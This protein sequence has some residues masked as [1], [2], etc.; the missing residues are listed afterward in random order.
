MVNMWL[1]NT[2]SI[3]NYRDIKNLIPKTLPPR[4]PP[5]ADPAAVRAN[6]VASM[7]TK[8]QEAQSAKGKGKASSA[9]HAGQSARGKQK[10]AAPPP[11][12]SMPPDPMP[13]SA[14]LT[15]DASTSQ[16]PHGFSF[17]LPSPI[18]KRKSED[19]PAEDMQPPKL[20]KPPAP[21]PRSK[22]SVPH[23]KPSF[24]PSEPGP[25]PHYGSQHPPPSLASDALQPQL[26]APSSA[27]PDPHDAPMHTTDLTESE[28]P[29]PRW[30]PPDEAA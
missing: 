28:S 21:R 23:S 11:Q 16:T 19:H 1:L 22:P 29:W 9:V 5:V 8:K 30:P 18:L 10:A 15:P 25:L 26:P 12:V 7:A 4:P 3:H 6:A 27:Q 24:S 2:H 17:A 20:R 13:G 14:A